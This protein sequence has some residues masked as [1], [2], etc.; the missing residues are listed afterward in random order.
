MRALRTLL[1]GLV[2]SCALASPASAIVVQYLS[3]DWDLANQRTINFL[4]NGGAMSVS[5]SPAAGHLDKVLDSSDS[6]GGRT[7]GRMFCVDVFNDAFDRID[8]THNRE[9]GVHEYVGA[10]G[11]T[12]WTTPAGDSD[13]FR[14]L[15]S[16][17]RTA[18]LVNTFG[19]DPLTA[20]QKV[21]LNVAI[22]DAAYGSR[23]QYV[24]G[25]DAAQ[26]T[27]YNAYRAAYLLGGQDFN[28][29]WYDNN[30]PDTDDRFQDFMEAVPEPGTIMLLGTGLLGSGLVWRRRR[31]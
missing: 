4:F 15:G 3:V 2:V 12:G 28:Y 14:D 13:H 17:T 23:I 11:T 30:F 31:K 25:L 29:R 21:A 8:A 18:W 7:I 20:S 1:F 6:P 5:V 24:S 10:D 16:L 19:D 9:Y 26:T 22:W 27:Q